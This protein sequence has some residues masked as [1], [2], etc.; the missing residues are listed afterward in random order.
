MSYTEFLREVIDGTWESEETGYAIYEPAKIIT[1]ADQLS[2][3]DDVF[4]AEPRRIENLVFTSCE[5]V[6]HQFANSSDNKEVFAAAL[7]VDTETGSMGLSFNTKG[8]YER[9]VRERYSNYSAAD[10]SSV[11]GVRYNEG[12][13]PFRYFGQD[14]VVPELQ[15]IMDAY[16]AINTSQCF[17][18]V[19]KKIA[20]P[21]SFFESQLI[22]VALNVVARLKEKQLPLNTTEDFMFYVSLHDVDE[23]TIVRLMK[24]T[25]PTS[26]F[27]KNFP[28]YE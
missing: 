16:Y 1:Y 20:F 5:R 17:F 28:Q 27:R 6:I 23:E 18:D 22:S 25:V 9:L 12:D 10:L 11:Y 19:K 4:Y 15:E 26:I 2:D 7:F 21:K 8:E 24:K 3:G 14:F 13:F